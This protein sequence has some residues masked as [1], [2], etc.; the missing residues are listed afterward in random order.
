MSPNK[1]G[2]T[3][4]SEIN[5]AGSYERRY[6]KTRRMLQNDAA[7][8]RA[9]ADRELAKLEKAGKIGTAAYKRAQDAFEKAD[10]ADNLARAKARA[11]RKRDKAKK[12][13][14]MAKNSSW[15]G[16]LYNRQIKR[17]RTPA[18]ARATVRMVKGAKKNAAPKRRS[19][20]TS[21][22]RR[23]S[24]TS[25]TRS[26]RRYPPDPA[27]PSSGYKP[28]LKRAGARV[29]KSQFVSEQLGRG[30]S[31]K[32]AEAA[33][34]L[35]S[36]YYSKARKAKR[37]QPRTYG[38]GQY[39]ALTARAGSKKKGTYFYRTKNGHVR[40]IP[41]HALLGYKSAREMSQVYR[42]GTDTQRER[43]SKRLQALY[44]RR[45]KAADR[46][47]SR[48]RKGS[49]WFSPNA[50][51]ET[52]LELEEWQQMQRNASRKKRKTTKRRAKRATRNP[53][54]AG[55]RDS[56]GR[57]IKK[58]ATRK[59][60]ATTK[61]R[62]TRKATTKR[63]ASTTKRRASA[64][65]RTS[66]RKTTTRRKKIGF[67]AMTKKARCEAARKGGRKTARKTRKPGRRKA[68]CKTAYKRNAKGSYLA[69]RKKATANPK[70][71]TKRTYKRNATGAAYKAELKN[72]FKYGLIVTAGYVGHRVLTNLADKHLM[73]KI[74]YLNEGAAAPYRKL[75][76]G[77]LVAAVGVPLTVRVLPKHAG[78]AA[79]GIAAS[80][81][82]GLIVEAFTMAKQPELVEAVSNYPNA[83]GYAQ[84]SGYG[85][86]YEFSP[87][88]VYGGQSGYGEF[89]ETQPI[90]G[91]EQAAAGYGQADPYGQ[92]LTQ[93]AAG[94]GN[95]TQ[96]YANESVGEYYAYGAEG[97]GEYESAPAAG[98]P[99]GY[100]Y[101]GIQ[102]NLNSAEQMLDVAEAAAGFGNDM[103]TQAA[104]GFGSD[105]PLQ[106]TVDPSIRAMNIPDMPGGSRA[107]I[108]AGGDG[109]FG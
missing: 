47:A 85:S 101:D 43:L 80:F 69:L 16:S 65:R 107:G 96:M 72:A 74:G 31:K 81:L 71:K 40:K 4:I 8:D 89:Y 18:Q 26:A 30:R 61:R 82:H 67:A 50:G 55:K 11:K 79:A 36:G 91:L 108:L 92:M 53:R 59:K 34:K 9:A 62:T 23:A 58:R 14:S 57:F 46:A 21:G 83:P 60:T 10:R 20:G 90:P 38:K 103:L 87:H 13:E 99:A 104:A 78:V 41:D 102:P 12:D 27:R 54:G 70:R 86:Y 37:K 63:R 32:Q 24:G 52:I 88:Q 66:K 22:T 48:A 106:S 2:V 25:G 17:G 97:I 45:E 33:W 100:T 29:T 77:A 95:L 98:G 7:D 64:K 1:R 76:T 6:A 28:N 39:R 94:Y 105:I 56:K 49:A 75:L 3:A 51:D 19:S 84:Y 68:P 73:S 44:D 5:G 15:E 93:A 35:A 42:A 109:I